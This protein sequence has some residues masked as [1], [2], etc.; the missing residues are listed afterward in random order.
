MH[1]M[2]GQKSSSAEGEDIGSQEQ[3]AA[4]LVSESN[5]VNRLLSKSNDIC[6]HLIVYLFDL[7]NFFFGS[8]L[9]VRL[10]CELFFCSF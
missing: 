8:L 10:F 9:S 4:G 6:V 5:E 2:E 7:T 1:G 3:N